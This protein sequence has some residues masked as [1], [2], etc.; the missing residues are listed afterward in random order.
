MMTA[1]DNMPS[2][3]RTWIYQASRPFTEKE[4][5]IVL[6]KLEDFISAW[7]SHGAKIKAAADI[8]FDLFIVIAVDESQQAPSGCSIDKSLKVINELEIALNIKLTERTAVACK[9]NEVVSIIPPGKF[10]EAVQ[11]GRINYNS[12]IFNNMVSN[13]GDFR[14]NWLI[15]AGNSWLSKYF[16]T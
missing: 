2:D 15:P 9:E 11:N 10:K 12:L 6:A 7:D 8:F 16:N 14:Q 4:K 13:L 3:S 5:E 1:F